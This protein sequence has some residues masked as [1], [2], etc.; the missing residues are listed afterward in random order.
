M[1]ENPYASLH[2][3]P[4]HAACSAFP[5]DRVLAAACIVWLIGVGLLAGSLGI[6]EGGAA[7]RQIEL[8]LLAYLLS[9]FPLGAAY[10]AAKYHLPGR[11]FKAWIVVSC[12]LLAYL[13]L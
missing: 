6:V 4:Q 5:W 13:I 9:G 2:K 10:G 12:G 7:R 1:D 8:S 3:N 11:R